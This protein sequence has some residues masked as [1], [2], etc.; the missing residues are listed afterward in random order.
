MSVLRRAMVL[1]VLAFPLVAS[2]A[3][4]KVRVAVMEFRPLGTEQAKA[5]LLSE[6]ALTRASSMKGF[7]V[8]GRSDIAALIGFEKQ[9]QV[10]G[11]SDD[12]GCLAEIGGALG[13]DFIMVGS[14]GRLGTLYRIDVKLVDTK[15]AE[16][17]GRI[18]VTVEGG[19]EDLV[20]LHSGGG[21]NSD[22]RDRRILVRAS[23]LERESLELAAHRDD[24]VHDRGHDARVD[25][26][27]LDANILEG[28]VLHGILPAPNTACVGTRL[29]QYRRGN[30]MREA[31]GQV[32]RERWT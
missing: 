29:G 12:Y 15:K 3:P 27:T 30:S 2:S 18:G 6:V 24:V 1:A 17:K 7:Q 28:V 14:L 23:D 5:D 21:T 4:R 25:E 26:V 22:D 8:I 19:E 16:V 20:E 10:V 9:R 31:A 11:C 13:V 32:R